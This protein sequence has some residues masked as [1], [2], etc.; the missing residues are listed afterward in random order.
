MGHLPDGH[1][2]GTPSRFAFNGC[3][4]VRAFSGNSPGISREGLAKAWARM[5][6]IPITE[7]AC[8]GCDS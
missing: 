7:T 1:V 8:A 4:Q 5:T 3:L 2:G 6:H